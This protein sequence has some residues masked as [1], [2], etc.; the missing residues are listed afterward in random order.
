MSVDAHSGPRGGSVAVRVDTENRVTPS[1]LELVA[2]F[3]S[4]YSYE[5]AAKTKFLS[6][7]TVRNRIKAAVVRSGARNPS[8]LAAMAVEQRIIRLNPATGIFE[9]VQDLRIAGE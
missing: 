2:L 9:P 3:A 5:D 8:H 7:F 4:G 1:E 6:Y